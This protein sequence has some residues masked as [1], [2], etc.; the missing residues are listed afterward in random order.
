MASITLNT[1]PRRFCN[2]AKSLSRV[3]CSKRAQSLVFSN[4]RVTLHF[5]CRQ[6]SLHLVSLHGRLTE[7]QR[8][9]EKDVS[10]RK[11]L[12]GLRGRRDVRGIRSSKDDKRPEGIVSEK[13]IKLLDRWDVPWDWKTTL[14]TMMASGLSFLLTGLIET[15]ALSYLGLR[16]G[17]LTSFDERATLLFVDQFL[18]TAVGLAV[19]Y[20]FVKPY[21]PLPDDLFRFEWKEPL[22]LYKGWLLWGGIGLI[23]AALGIALTGVALS[24]LNGEPPQRE[25]DALVQLLPLIGASN[26]STA[27]LIGVTGILAPIYEETVFRGFLMT[28]LTK[29]FPT[30]AAVVLSASIFAFV[31][32][33]PGEFPQLFALGAVLGFAYAQTRNLL[34]SITIHALWNSAVIILL[35]FLR[36]Q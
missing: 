27:C 19:I 6:R 8:G 5:A 12:I 32:L 1:F 16:H 29:W 7:L 2:L 15:A 25:V 14:L 36:L 23:V 10:R 35:T 18:I 13:G 4:G 9:L 21:Q 3:T 17:R 30:P 24:A 26:I 33:T 22:N 34:T 31:H 28:S 20:A 11:E